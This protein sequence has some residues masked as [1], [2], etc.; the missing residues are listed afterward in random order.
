MWLY[1]V[2]YK[3]GTIF[4]VI[5]PILFFYRTLRGREDKKRVREKYG[6]YAKTFQEIIKNRK[7]IHLHGASVG[8]SMSLLPV[9]RRLHAAYPDFIVIMTCTTLGGMNILNKHQTNWLLPVFM[10]IDTPQ[11]VDR[12]FKMFRPLL[13]II[14]DTEIWPVYLRTAIIYQCPV[15]SLNMRLS[16]RSQ[17]R[18]Q[19]LSGLF[20]YILQAYHM[21][22]VQNEQT[23]AFLRCYT[24]QIM[25]V[26]ANLKWT[27]TPPSL[28]EERIKSFKDNLQDKKIVLL[29]SSHDDEEVRL[30]DLLKSQI[31]QDIL[32][33]IVP[34]HPHR[35]PL[36]VKQI[37]EI[38]QDFHIQ[39][40]S[41][42]AFP[43]TQ[44]HIYIFDNFGDT[45]FAIAIADMVCMGKSFTLKNQGGH[46]PIEVM[47]QKKPLITGMYMDYFSEIMMLLLQ[48]EAVVQVPPEHVPACVQHFKN[49]PADADKIA[50]NAYQF[51]DYYHQQAWFFWY[52][53]Q[54]MIDLKKGNHK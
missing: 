17:K 13:T 26:S 19:K 50:E 25:R 54:K 35:T 24:H 4:H 7:T 1:R 29:L 6:L 36:I 21:F 32:F 47:I 53:V 23:A 43:Q 48:K 14:A 10:P 12:F 28:D 27:I 22:S 49:H 3:I 51:Y 16:L 42:L 18:W 2:Y 45:H 38:S 8:E 52:D 30:S 40:H 31:M 37:K 33:V 34:R 20:S 9:A 44:T 41:Q 15:V 5:A 11:A 46:N 39:T